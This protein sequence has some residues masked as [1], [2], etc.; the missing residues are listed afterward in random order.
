M[1][2]AGDPNQPADVGTPSGGPVPYDE[3][4]II[5]FSLNHH[6]IAEFIRILLFF[7]HRW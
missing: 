6:N 1:I 7:N 3:K 5:Y 2:P 4:K